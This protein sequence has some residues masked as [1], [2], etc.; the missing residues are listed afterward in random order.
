MNVV[1]YGW[2]LTKWYCL[3]L[4]FQHK[5]LQLEVGVNVTYICGR[6]IN[7]KL[8]VGVNCQ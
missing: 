5:C 1:I 7:L 4:M 3:G 6:G 2:V 8:I